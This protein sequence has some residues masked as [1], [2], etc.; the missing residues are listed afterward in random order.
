MYVLLLIM[1]VSS[2]DVFFAD[3]SADSAT[4]DSLSGELELELKD[5]D[6]MLSSAKKVQQHRTLLAQ[7]FMEQRLYGRALELLDLA[8][9]DEPTNAELSYLAAINSAYIAKSQPDL[10]TQYMDKSEFYYYRAVELEPRNPGY[11][12]ALVVFLLYERT[13]VE[14]SL[15][16]IRTLRELNSKDVNYAFLEGH[17]YTTIGEREKAISAYRDIT[18]NARATSDQKERAASFIEKAEGE[19]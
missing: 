19:F 12:Y 14:E 16:Y 6:A 17:A 7:K 15:P 18:R 4:I 13:Q 8:L 10:N 5:L 1:L 2:C 11:I 9:K 3:S